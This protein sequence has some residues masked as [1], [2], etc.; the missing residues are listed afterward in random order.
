M[1]RALPTIERRLLDYT[2]AAAYLSISLRSMKQLAADGKVPKVLIGHRVL[3]DKDDLDAF[4]E[5]IK[6]AS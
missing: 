5:K 2:K 3:F 4:I 6:R 1:S